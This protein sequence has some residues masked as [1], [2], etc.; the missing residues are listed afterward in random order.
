MG[1]A[2][3]FK[4]PGQRGLRGVDTQQPKEPRPRTTA[5]VANLPSARQTRRG[6]HPLSCQT[7]TCSVHSRRRLGGGGGCGVAA[8]SLGTAAGPASCVALAGG[9]RCAWVG[10]S[11]GE[12]AGGFTISWK[13]REWRAKWESTSNRDGGCGCVSKARSS[14]RASSMGTLGIDARPCVRVRQPRVSIAPRKSH[15]PRY[16]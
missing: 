12:G 13:R 14:S 15:Q 11:L 4:C 7:R 10:G 9:R 16:L 6:R 5:G 8:A 3:A 1:R 2:P